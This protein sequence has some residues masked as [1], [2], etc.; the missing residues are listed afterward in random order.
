MIAEK[1]VQHVRIDYMH[2][3]KTTAQVKKF[4]TAINEILDDTYFRI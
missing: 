3:A 4:N 1:T 2:D